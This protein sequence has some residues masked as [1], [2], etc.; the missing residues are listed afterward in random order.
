[1]GIENPNSEPANCCPLFFI[2]HYPRTSHA[3]WTYGFIEV[4]K[5]NRG[6]HLRMFLNEAS[7]DWS[8]SVLFFAYAFNTQPLSHLHF[9]AQEK[10]FHTQSSFAMKSQLSL[11]RN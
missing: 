3:P 5:K 2:R 7:E 4:Q 10:V 11:S 6:T 1:M 9:S 8:K